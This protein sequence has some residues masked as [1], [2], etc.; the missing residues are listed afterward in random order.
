MLVYMAQMC[1]PV[2]YAFMR[3]SMHGS[4]PLSF[5]NSA[6]SKFICTKFASGSLACQKIRG[7]DGVQEW[8]KFCQEKFG[9]GAAG[10]ME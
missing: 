4:I 7:V 6:E 10:F 8:T 1:G 3:R 5:G 9:T 2:W